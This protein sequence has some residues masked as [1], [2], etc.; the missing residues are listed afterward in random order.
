MEQR[1]IELGGKVVKCR[2]QKSL[3]VLI[4]TPVTHPPDR[5]TR[6]AATLLTGSKNAG[7]LT[8]YPASPMLGPHGASAGTVRSNL[9]ELRKPL[10]CTSCRAVKTG[11]RAL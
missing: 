8:P 7:N 3:W 11:I 5:L 10:P 1:L 9:K 2:E 6:C 4:R